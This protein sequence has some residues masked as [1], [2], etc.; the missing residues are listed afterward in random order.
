MQEGE[1]EE[2]VTGDG[3]SL[4]VVF[5][6]LRE[7]VRAGAP[8]K[9]GAALDALEALETRAKSQFSPSHF[10]FFVFFLHCLKL[11]AWAK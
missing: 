6:S 3:E 10:S 8:H 4:S 9:V 11:S 7:A 1:S 2:R 5:V